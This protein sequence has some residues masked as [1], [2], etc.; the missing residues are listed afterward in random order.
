MRP[1]AKLVG[2]KPSTW[3]G[4][5]LLGIPIALLILFMLVYLGWV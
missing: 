1:L 3:I 4:D 5:L 2:I